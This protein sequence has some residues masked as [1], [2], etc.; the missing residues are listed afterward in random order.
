MM[1][2]EFCLLF[3]LV[4]FCGALGLADSVSCFEC[5]NLQDKRCGTTFDFAPGSTEAKEKYLKKC[6]GELTFCRKLT[7]EDDFQG[8]KTNGIVVSRSCWTSPGKEGFEPEV[9]ECS[10]MFK[11]VACY[12]K[13]DLCNGSELVRASTAILFIGLLPLL[14]SLLGF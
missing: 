13:G 1:T 3:G 4:V 14:C 5:S 7:Y 11:G 6:E 12:C 2:P 8:K 10:E 9:K